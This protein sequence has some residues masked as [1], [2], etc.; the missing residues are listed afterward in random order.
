[1]E[2]QPFKDHLLGTAGVFSILFC[3]FIGGYA[4]PEAPI[5]PHGATRSR[6]HLCSLRE[7]TLG[8]CNRPLAGDMYCWVWQRAMKICT[9]VS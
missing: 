2:K 3:L 6:H 5:L 8:P 7:A 4:R 9:C 1:M